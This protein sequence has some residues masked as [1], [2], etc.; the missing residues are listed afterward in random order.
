[1]TNEF[2]REIEEEAR[3]ARLQNFW[4][5]YGNWLIGAS[6]AIVLGTASGV[7][8]RA[9]RHGAQEAFTEKLLQASG[10][11]E[12]FSALASEQSGDRRALA[13]LRLAGMQAEA[14]KHEDAL[15]AYADAAKNGRE[16]GVR[17]LATVLALHAQAQTGAQAGDVPPVAA[18]FEP[19]AREAEGWSLLKAGNTADALKIFTAL[20]DG[21]ETPLPQRQ[22]MEMVSAF[23]TVEAK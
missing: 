21:V 3:A 22:R 6:V 7:G 8:V 14:G 19:L 2:I 18:A 20:R 11:E 13:A 15:A 17:A 12:A 4:K 23:L 5:T 9:Y 10:K 1:M 16:E